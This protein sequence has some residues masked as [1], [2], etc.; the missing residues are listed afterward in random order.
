[1]AIRYQGDLGNDKNEDCHKNPSSILN[2]GADCF[3]AF[4]RRRQRDADGLNNIS[5]KR[6]AGKK[7]R[8][9]V[10]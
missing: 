6:L 4:W 2:A 1:V 8:I 9:E 5:E 3:D 10:K 7:S